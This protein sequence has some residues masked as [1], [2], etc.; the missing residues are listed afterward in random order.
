MAVRYY[1]VPKI[2]TG[3]L[4]TPASPDPFRP[5]YFD[6]LVYTALDYVQGSGFCM[7]VACDTTAPQHTAIVANADA[8]AA[9]TDLAQTIGANLATVQAALASF[10]IPAA[11]VTSAMTY[12]VLVRWIARLFM[13]ARAVHGQSGGRLLPAGVTLASTLGDLTA[14]Q[15]TALTNAAQS[16]GCSTTG[17]TLATTLAA[18]LKIVADQITLPVFVGKQGL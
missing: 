17:I 4:A 10:S 15:R 2:G 8:V 5:K 13:V 7:L 3:S 16:L 18:A 1:L 11:W 14:G 6:G 9:P 12:A